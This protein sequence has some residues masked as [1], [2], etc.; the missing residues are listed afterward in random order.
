MRYRIENC[1]KGRPYWTIMCGADNSTATVAIIV[2]RVNMMRQKRSTTIAANFQ[3]LMTS[4]SSSAFRI[5]AVMN[6]SSLRMSCSSRCTPLGGSAVSS[7][8]V[9]CGCRRKPC[10]KL[11]VTDPVFV[12]PETFLKSSSMSS[13]FA[14]K[15]FDERSFSSNSF[16]RLFIRMVLRVIF[17]PGRPILRNHGSH[18]KK[19]DLIY[20]RCTL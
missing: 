10:P 2:N 3:S 13:T 8:V 5:R 15:L 17:L 18:C 7:M 19:T 1:M 20:K 14:N 4:A 16:I 6:C 12:P 9:G 11:V